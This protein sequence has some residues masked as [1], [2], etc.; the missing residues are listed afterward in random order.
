MRPPVQMWWAAATRTEGRRRARRQRRLQ[1]S[2]RGEP[3]PAAAPRGGKARAA[4]RRASRASRGASLRS[5]SERGE[6]GG[7]WQRA[8]LGLMLLNALAAASGLQRAAAQQPVCSRLALPAGPLPRSPPCSSLC[9]VATRPA[10]TPPEPL[11]TAP[12]LRLAAAAPPPPPFPPG[13]P[14]RWPPGSESPPPRA[15]RSQSSSGSMPRTTTSRWGPGPRRCMFL[16]VVVS[17]RVS[18]AAPCSNPRSGGPSDVAPGCIVSTSLRPSIRFPASPQHPSH[19]L[20]YPSDKP[21]TLAG[22]PLPH[23]VPSMPPR[24]PAP[25]PPPPRRTPL[26][27]PSSWRT[28]P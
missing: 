13:C 14:M 16:L 19:Y 2:A 21:F 24:L 12:T 9:C 22:L 10:P 6:Q 26:T 20:H 25:P 18:Q 15:P 23:C 7:P 11:P 4:A 8:G 5:A 28:T 27:S 3:P 1:P 17:G